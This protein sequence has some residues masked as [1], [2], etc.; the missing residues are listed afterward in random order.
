MSSGGSQAAGVSANVRAVVLNTPRQLQALD[1]NPRASGCRLIIHNDPA[2]RVGFGRNIGG[3]QVLEADGQGVPLVGPQD[4]GAGALVVTQSHLARR[5]GPPFRFSP[6][7]A[8]RAGVVFHYVPSQGED[9]SGRI[10]R[11]HAIEG[12]ELV[13]CYHVSGNGRCYRRL[14]RREEHEQGQKE[15]ESRNI[16]PKAPTPL[17]ISFLCIH[18]D[19]TSWSI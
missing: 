6:S 12:D 18:H 7:I 4:N 5:E 2:H 16:S 11:T 9:H 17:P 15:D 10:D 19:C 14:R 3:K 13:E 1:M 8:Q